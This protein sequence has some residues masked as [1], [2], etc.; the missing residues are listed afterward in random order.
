M[1][2]GT[3]FAVA[4]VWVAVTYFHVEIEVV[5]VFLILSFIFVG[6]MIVVGLVVAPLMALTRKRRSKF[7]ESMG[8]NTISD[9]ESDHSS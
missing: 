6:A 1:F 8:E 7:L 4:F 5:K 2:T 3:L 9:E